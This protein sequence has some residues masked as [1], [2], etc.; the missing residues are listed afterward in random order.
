M[1]NL[2]INSKVRGGDLVRLR[3]DDVLAGGRVRDRATMIRKK[4]GRLAQSRSPSKPAVL[5]ASGRLPEKVYLDIQR[6]FD[7]VQAAIEVLS[8]LDF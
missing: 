7:Q 4:T 1:F 5:S 3:I 2:A 8:K 6:E